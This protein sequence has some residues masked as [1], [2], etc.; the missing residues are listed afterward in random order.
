MYV[1]QASP[2]EKSSSTF[3]H[4]FY[5][6]WNVDV[7]RKVMTYAEESGGKRKRCRGGG[8]LFLFAG[9]CRGS[10]TLYEETY[11]RGPGEKHCTS[12]SAVVKSFSRLTWAHNSGWVGGR[13][14]HNHAA[15]TGHV[16]CYKFVRAICEWPAG[17]GTLA[18]AVTGGNVGI[19][20]CLWDDGY[21]VD[22]KEDE[23]VLQSA[24]LSTA[25]MF[26]VVLFDI[27]AQMDRPP[28]QIIADELVQ[29][30]VL[31][32]L[33]K[34][35]CIY[36]AFSLTNSTLVKM[37]TGVIEH[38]CYA[39]QFAV[40]EWSVRQLVC[41]D[42]QIGVETIELIVD[43]FSVSVP[44]VGWLWQTSMWGQYPVYQD[45]WNEE[46]IIEEEIEQDRCWCDCGCRR[47][48]EDCDNAADDE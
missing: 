21:R 40:M 4:P 11:P 3:A 47:V 1:R 45:E 43:S 7:Y 29:A 14:A 35:Q 8:S 31:G 10:K 36:S 9:V 39:Q 30:V 27:L 6:G 41:A 2:H 26:G 44:L 34:L 17:P 18:A 20:A 23:V 33:E 28:L 16:G 24:I 19:V 46:E 13:H 25:G 22:K 42:D 48:V 12:N 5:D 38:A 37:S 15:A 32:D